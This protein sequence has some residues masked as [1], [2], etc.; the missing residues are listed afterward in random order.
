MNKCICGS[1]ALE[2]CEVDGYFYVYCHDCEHIGVMC[3]TAEEAVDAWTS[4]SAS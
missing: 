3:E 2:V 1:E 4:E